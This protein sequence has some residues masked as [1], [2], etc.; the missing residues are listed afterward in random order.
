MIR[1]T[2]GA[3]LPREVMVHVVIMKL[4]SD[5]AWERQWF[6]PPSSLAARARGSELFEQ[7]DEEYEGRGEYVRARHGTNSTGIG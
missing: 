4:V 5:I 6:L 2:L 3:F 7:I 1:P